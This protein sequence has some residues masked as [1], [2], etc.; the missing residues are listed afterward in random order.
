VDH[1]WIKKVVPVWA[2]RL[3]ERQ[4]DALSRLWWAALGV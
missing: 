4:P 2:R 1:K 3:A